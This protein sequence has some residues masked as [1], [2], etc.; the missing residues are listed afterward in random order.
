MQK[1][2][3]TR[4]PASLV[5]NP[6]S[7]DTVN[8]VADDEETG[9]QAFIEPHLLPLETF[10]HVP[11]EVKC[12]G[13]VRRPPA[14]CLLSASGAE[15]I[16]S[17]SEFR[18]KLLQVSNPLIPQD[19]NSARSDGDEEGYDTTGRLLRRDSESPFAK[20]EIWRRSLLGMSSGKSSFT[21]LH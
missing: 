7:R 13:I 8:Y 6:N 10:D 12:T 20:E 18:R 3:R 9:L 2:R 21:L 16:P 17:P 14:D 11:I 4:V 19:T 5:K 1:T 15:P